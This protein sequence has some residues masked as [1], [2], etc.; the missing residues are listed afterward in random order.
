[1]RF[2]LISKKQRRQLEQKFSPFKSQKGQDKWVIFT[3]LPFKRNGFFLD[4][5][6]ADGVLHSNSFALEKMFGWKG[7]CIEPNPAFF[8]A[9]QANRKCFFDNAVISDQ[10]EEVTFRIDNG[11]LGGIVASDTDNNNQVRA[12][13]LTQAT[14]LT[15]TAKVLK[16]VL[17]AHNAPKVIDYFSLDVEGSEERIIRS[18]DFDAYQFKCITIERPTP[19]V[20]QTLFDNGYVFVKNFKFDSFYIHESLA[21]ENRIELESFEQI[22]AKDW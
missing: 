16:D 21:A 8:E 2:Q 4:L 12:E 5:A 3:A 17:D 15:M 14:T 7:I 1:M 22:P 11:Q 20:N 19:V 13:E 10:P 18:F 6:A 9:L